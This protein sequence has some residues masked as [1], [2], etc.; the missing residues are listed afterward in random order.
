MP[1]VNMKKMLT[2][3]RTEKYAV[4]AFDVSNLDMAMAVTE[5]AEEK[6]SPVILMGLTVDLAGDSLSGECAVVE[7]HLGGERDVVTRDPRFLSE[8]LMN[9]SL[10]PCEYMFDD[11]ACGVLVLDS[12]L[13]IGEDVAESHA[14]EVG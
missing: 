12:G 5:A 13:K 2:D 14:A 6:K 7:V 4:G 1:L 8:R 9:S 3:A 11:V 10:V